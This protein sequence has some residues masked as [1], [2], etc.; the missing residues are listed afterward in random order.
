MN[1]DYYE[2]RITALQALLTGAH[3]RE[4]E[5]HTRLIE[6]TAVI[7]QLANEIKDRENEI[8]VLHEELNHCTPDDQ[9]QYCTECGKV[10]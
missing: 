6:K 1:S 5:V 9:E 3:A 10:L 8:R 4:E 2:N 7:G